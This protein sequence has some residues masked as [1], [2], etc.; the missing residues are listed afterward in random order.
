MQS[1][2]ATHGNIVTEPRR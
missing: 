1:S 2:I